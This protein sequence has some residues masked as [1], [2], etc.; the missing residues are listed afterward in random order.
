[1]SRR[2][3]ALLVLSLALLPAGNA[4]A[5]PQFADSSLRREVEEL[6][7]RVLEL[8]RQ[9][10]VTAVELARLRQQVAEL[11][12]ARGK[13]AAQRAPAGPASP[14]PSR[15]TA[16]PPAREPVAPPERIEPIEEV[17][18]PM[19]TPSAPVPSAPAAPAPSAPAPAAGSPSDASAPQAFYDRGYALYYQGHYAEAEASFRRLLEVDP[20]GELADNAHYW[21]GE[22]RYARG[23][24]KGALAAFREVIERHPD[25]NKVPDALYKAGLSLEAMGDVEGA[26]VTYR[27]VARRFPGTSAATA[28]EERRRK[29]P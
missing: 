17:D 29:L 12:A 28:A 10:A 2:R 18:L 11:E 8:Q 25:G 7:A 19:P 23:D 6:K 26:R 24:F 22:C 3:A 4:A 20:N 14:P 21:I 16:P 5:A 27:E 9:A 13:P 1:M 15:E